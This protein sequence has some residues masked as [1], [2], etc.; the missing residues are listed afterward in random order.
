MG[1]RQQR[2]FRKD[3]SQHSQELLEQK[4]VQ[5]ILRSK[6]VINGELTSLTSEEIQLKDLRFNKHTLPLDDVEEIIYDVEAPY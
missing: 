4:S 1:K 3:I 6:V 2:I 5:V